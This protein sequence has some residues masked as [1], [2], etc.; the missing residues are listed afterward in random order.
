MEKFTIQQTKST[1]LVEFDPENGRIRM[2]GESYP[3]NP[4]KFYEPIWDRL[5]DYLKSGIA[6]HLEVDMELTYFNSSSSK[7]LMNL[8]EMLE[9]AARDGFSIVVN[10]WTHPENESAL[11]AGEEFKEDVPFLT[12]NLKQTL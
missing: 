3:E 6:T 7:A 11:E 12:F 1:P 2:E 8:F 4:V 5:R 10:W 9:T